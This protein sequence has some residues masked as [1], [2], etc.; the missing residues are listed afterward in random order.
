VATAR[1][2]LDGEQFDC[3]LLVDVLHLIQDPRAA[4]CTFAPL[5][6]AGATV[7]ARVPR[8]SRLTTAYRVIRGDQKIREMGNYAQ[9]GVHFT[10]PRTLRRW[11]GSAG[12]Q[13][14]SVAN[15][16]PS[17]SAKYP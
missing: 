8:V 3:L 17:T 9:T 7:I 6:R 15:Q 1:T 12:C 5:L 2:K 4:V 10:S 16:I 11:L 13:I 14:E